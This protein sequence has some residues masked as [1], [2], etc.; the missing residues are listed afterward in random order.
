MSELL[1]ER[2]Q[3]MKELSLIIGK[4]AVIGLLALMPIVVNA[5][6]YK[7]MYRPTRYDRYL[8]T[9]QAGAPTAVFQSTSTLA[10]SGSAYSATPMLDEDGTATL[11]GASAP[12]KAPGGPRRIVN[13]DGDDDDDTENGTPI[14]D[15]LLPLLLLACAYLCTRVFRKKHA[16]KR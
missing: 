2:S 7:N 4:V 14:G 15:A 16:M 5:V 9:T 1:K 11:G 13:P 12:A 6:E 10:G 8:A 3:V